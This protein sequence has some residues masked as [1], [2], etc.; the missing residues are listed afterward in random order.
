MNVHCLECLATHKYDLERVD[1]MRTS[2]HRF[3]FCRSSFWFVISVRKI[4][5]N[6][7]FSFLANDKS[8]KKYFT[9]ME[10]EV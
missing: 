5:G 3:S 9:F 8:F 4:K 1:L 7:N 6:K 10:S 2:M